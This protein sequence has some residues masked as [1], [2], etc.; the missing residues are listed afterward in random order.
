M[1]DLTFSSYSC[2]GLNQWVGGIAPQANITAY[3]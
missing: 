2:A 1:C 3:P